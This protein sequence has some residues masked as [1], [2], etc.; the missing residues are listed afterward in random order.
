MLLYNGG[1]AV[2]ASAKVCLSIMVP[3]IQTT[4]EKKSVNMV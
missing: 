1:K 4:V 2:N 3:E